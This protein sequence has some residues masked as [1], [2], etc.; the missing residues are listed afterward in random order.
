MNFST[1]AAAYIESLTQPRRH[2]LRPNSVRLYTSYTKRLLEHFADVDM[3]DVRNGKVKDYVATLHAQELSAGTI[4]GIYQTLRSIVYSVRNADGE[5][6]YQQ[7]FDTNWLAIPEIEPTTQPCA[8]PSDV[9]HSLSTAV[10][11]IVALLAATGLRASEALSLEAE[12]S[13][14]NSYDAASGLVRLRVGKTDNAART[15]LLPS[16]FRVWFNQRVPVSG[17][18]FPQTYQQLHTALSHAKLPNAHSYRRFRITHLRKVG[19]NESI[20]RAQVGHSRSDITSRYD[21][22]ADDLNFTREQV[23]AAGVGF[24][25]GVTTN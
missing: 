21:R 12:V 19:M 10:N 14:E 20:L 1:A 8:L 22:S 25:F 18:L 24:N 5:R 2:T 9:E 15:V 6:L 13:A 11:P 16:L 7:P 4:T 23:E 3:A 17:K